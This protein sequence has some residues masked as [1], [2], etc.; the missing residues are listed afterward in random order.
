MTLPNGYTALR[1]DEGSLLTLL[2]AAVGSPTPRF[3]WFPGAARGRRTVTPGVVMA[4][5]DGFVTINSTLT[6]PSL[7]RADAGNYACSVGNLVTTGADIITRVFTVTVKCKPCVHVRVRVCMCVCVCVCMRAC[8][9][10][11][12]YVCVSKQV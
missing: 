11:R 7:H 4:D 2:C 5:S 1:R 12:V 8:V 6:I 10:V 3:T 9:C